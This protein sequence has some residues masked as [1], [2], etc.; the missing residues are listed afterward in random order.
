[1]APANWAPSREDRGSPPGEI[2]SRF[3]PD[4]YPPLIQFVNLPHPDSVYVLFDSYIFLNQNDHVKNK[5]L[6]DSAVPTRFLL[7]R[8]EERRVGREGRHRGGRE[9]SEKAKSQ[10]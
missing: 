2:N 5:E 6:G 1:M 8:S 9:E 10:K 4:I 7:N 3:E